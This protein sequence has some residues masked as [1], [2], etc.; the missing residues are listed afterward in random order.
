MTKIEFLCLPRQGGK[1]TRLIER[2]CE[3]QDEGYDPVYIVVPKAA[4]ANHIASM[5]VPVGADP[6]RVVLI[7][8]E[9]VMRGHLRGTRPCIAGVD[10]IDMCRDDVDL[11]REVIYAAVNDSILVTHST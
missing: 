8:E 9:M 1:T 10:D 11:M 3:L 5:L 4:H 6:S 2:V 7:S